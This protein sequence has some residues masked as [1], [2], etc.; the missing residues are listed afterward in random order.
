MRF[1]IRDGQRDPPGSKPSSLECLSATSS[2][3]TSFLPHAV[4]GGHSFTAQVAVACGKWWL[5]ALMK[6][7]H[8]IREGKVSQQGIPIFYSGI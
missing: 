5:P 1:S 2:S 3:F 8:Q 7:E 4:E 6:A